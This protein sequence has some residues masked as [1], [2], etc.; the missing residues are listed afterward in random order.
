MSDARTDLDLTRGGTVLPITRWGEPVMHQRTQPVTAF[1]EGLHT[2]VR[3]MF[4]TLAA[5]EGVGLAAT[6][7]GV[8]LALFIYDCPDADERR[9]I[10]VVCNPQLRLP[11]GRDR[12]L[13]Q[14]EEG[15]LSYPGAW[16]PLSRPD[17]S[18]CSGQNAFGD[19]IEVAGTGLLSRCLQHETDHLFGTVFG[20]RLPARIRRKLDA[21]QV[22]MNPRYPEDWPVHPKQPVS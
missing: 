15:C 8:S 3:D 7:V 12:R 20:D 19:D 6:Q 13:D 10:G 4:A 16:A 14:A 5:A 9:Q 1:D 2:L 21:Q 17:R 22:E 11:E 18:W